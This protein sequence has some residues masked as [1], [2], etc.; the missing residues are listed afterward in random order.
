MYGR[1]P[2]LPIRKPKTHPKKAKKTTTPP[3]LA[4]EELAGFPGQRRGGPLRHGGGHGRGR[5]GDALPR[6][7]RVGQ[8]LV[9]RVKGERLR[10]SYSS[11]PGGGVGGD[12][13]RFPQAARRR[14]PHVVCVVY[15]SRP[16]VH[17]VF[18]TPLVSPPARRRASVVQNIMSQFKR[19]CPKQQKATRMEFF[20]WCTGPHPHSEYCSKVVAA[21]F[22]VP[23]FSKA[24][25]KSGIKRPSPQLDTHTTEQQDNEKNGAAVAYYGDVLRAHERKVY[26]R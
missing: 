2:N 14:R 21:R 12:A 23:F 7:A 19:P 8:R 18:N 1:C 15:T 25:K 11:D 5:N 10:A 22:C 9:P 13:Q 6:A 26:T 17:S 24:L 3:H 16:R 20:G 4:F